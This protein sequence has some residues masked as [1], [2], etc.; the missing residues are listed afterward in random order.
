[1][2]VEEDGDEIQCYRRRCL[3]LSQSGSWQDGAGIDGADK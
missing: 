1:M 3:Y 2:I